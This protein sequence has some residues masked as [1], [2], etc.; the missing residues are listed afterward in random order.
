MFD[1][2]VVTDGAQFCSTE[3][4]NYEVRDSFS[5]LAPPPQHLDFQDA[6]RPVVRVTAWLPAVS[7]LS[8]RNGKCTYQVR[9]LGIA[10]GQNHMPKVLTYRMATAPC[11]REVDAC[12]SKPTQSVLM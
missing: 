12:C 2:M 6:T 7:Y 9:E 4:K 10:H 5:L 11:T 3:P 1:Y 8:W